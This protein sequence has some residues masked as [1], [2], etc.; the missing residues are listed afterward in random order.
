MRLK[1]LQEAQ[2]RGVKVARKTKAALKRMGGY[3][4]VHFAFRKGGKDNVPM[5]PCVAADMTARFPDGAPSSFKLILNIF[6]KRLLVS[7][8]LFVC[9]CV[10]CCCCCC[11]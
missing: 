5:P 1:T 7:V 6:T 4:L 3:R 9:V 2:E 10:C 11:C 8:C